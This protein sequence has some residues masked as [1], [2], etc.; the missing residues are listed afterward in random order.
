MNFL[1]TTGVEEDSL[2]TSGF[3]GVNMSLSKRVSLQCSDVIYLAARKRHDA[4]RQ[5]IR[6][7]IPIFLTFESLAAS[8]GSRFS[9]ILAWVSSE[10]SADP[11]SALDTSLACLLIVV[12][13]SRAFMNL[14][15]SGSTRLP[16]P[17]PQ[18]SPILR[19][20]PSSSSVF[21]PK[22]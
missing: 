4:K 7:A 20:C 16:S 10:A 12:V 3:S 22:S 13:T 5:K 21:K 8:A 9:I 1:D 2:S 19:F 15:S 11:F 17:L 6:T 18:A 14:H